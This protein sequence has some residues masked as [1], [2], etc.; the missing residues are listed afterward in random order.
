[1]EYTTPLDNACAKWQILRRLARESHILMEDANRALLAEQAGPAESLKAS[2]IASIRKTASAA[3]E[4]S[5][6]ERQL[7][8]AETARQLVDMG[9]PDL[10]PYAF[11]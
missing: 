3:D 4:Y 11:K 10:T 1:M 9:R 5:R 2:A 8:Q 6:I 7:I